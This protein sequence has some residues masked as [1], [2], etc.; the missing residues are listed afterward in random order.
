MTFPQVSHLFLVF[1]LICH[2]EIFILINQICSIFPASY[3]PKPLPST[4][5]PLSMTRGWSGNCGSNLFA[6]GE[7]ILRGAAGNQEG[8][9]RRVRGRSGSWGQK[10]PGRCFLRWCSSTKGPRGM[11]VPGQIVEHKLKRSHEKMDKY[12]N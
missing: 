1:R 11:L 4:W 2:S 6:D 5:N 9:Q 10:Y 12:A 8:E 3:L 7:L